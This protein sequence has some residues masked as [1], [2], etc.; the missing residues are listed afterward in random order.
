VAVADAAP[1]AL[2][3]RG[4]EALALGQ[5]LPKGEGGPP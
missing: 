2:L 5:R 4:G 1:L 3:L